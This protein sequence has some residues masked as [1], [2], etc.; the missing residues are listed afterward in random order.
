MVEN[1]SSSLAMPSKAPPGLITDFEDIR[2]F[3][4]RLWEVT[5]GLPIKIGS[6][7]RLPSAR[8][9]DWGIGLTSEN[10]DQLKAYSRTFNC[11]DF[12]EDRLNSMHGPDKDDLTSTRMMEG[13]EARMMRVISDMISDMIVYVPGDDKK[14]IVI[15]DIAAKNASLCLG[16]AS[17]LYEK[18]GNPDIGKR[19]E[20]HIVY[21][22]ASKLENTRDT[23]K[24]LGIRH[25][26]FLMDSEDYLANDVEPGSLDFIVSMPFLHRYSFPEFA[27]HAHDALIPG[28]AIVSGDIHSPL[29]SS[30]HHL[31]KLLRRIGLDRSRLD[32]LGEL[33]GDKLC[34]Q[35][36]PS[37]NS[38]EL[39][40][41]ESHTMEWLKIA[42][43]VR[44]AR[45]IG[46]QRVFILGAH[47]TSAERSEKFSSSGLVTSADDIRRAFPMAKLPQ[48]PKRM[49]RA[50]DFAV[51][52]TAMRSVK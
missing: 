34:E 45:K 19:I 52:S 36:N 46:N 28:G 26:A 20:F 47:D 30:P 43:N 32:M 25:R 1:D 37:M 24:D 23:L 3:D 18:S 5:R 14:P 8:Y 42:D 38:D 44:R 16:I 31:Y 21:P 7:A 9:A 51:I 12:Q 6:I 40:A 10:Q 22:S 4:E 17:L 35:S 50:S 15:A 27:R 33:F 13:I 41:L 39:A 29:W 11:A 48:I 2:R 49:E